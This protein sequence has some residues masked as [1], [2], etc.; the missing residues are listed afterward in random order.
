[1][2]AAT[3]TTNQEEEIGNNEVRVTDIDD[4]DQYITHTW[5]H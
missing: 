4:K 1:M 2:H 3:T 5:H